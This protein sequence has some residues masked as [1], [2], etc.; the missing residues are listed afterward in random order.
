MKKIPKGLFIIGS[1]KLLVAL[2]LFGASLGTFKLMDK[3][4]QDVLQQ[5]ILLLHVDPK[6]HFL[7]L[8]L[9]KISGIDRSQLKEIG[10][11]TFIY[12]ALYIV[13]GVGLLMGKHWAEYLVIIITGSLLPLEAYEIIEKTSALRI[14]ILVINLAVMVYLLRRLRQDKRKRIL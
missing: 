9:E 14:G 1:M 12:A 8:F 5:I 2:L 10:A 6:N 13:E 11:A 4:V 7:N 3:D